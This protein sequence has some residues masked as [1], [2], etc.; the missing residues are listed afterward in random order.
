MRYLFGRYE[1]I[2]DYEGN[3]IRADRMPADVRQIATD[4]AVR[5]ILR[6]AFSGEIT[7]LTRF[8]VLWRWNY[9]GAKVPFDEARKLAQSCSIDLTSEWTRPGFIRKEREFIR[10]LG[11]HER[12]FARAKEA[13]RGFGQEGATELID[14][15]KWPNLKSMFF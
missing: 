9:A 5:Q 14:G 3:I 1:K 11:P 8:Y 6:N 10:V 12:E 7:V 13:P 2:M 15:K 4:Y